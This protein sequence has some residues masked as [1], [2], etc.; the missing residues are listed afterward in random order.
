M[1]D[2]AHDDALVVLV[3]RVAHRGTVYS[4]S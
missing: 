4:R 2:D 3:L 1:L